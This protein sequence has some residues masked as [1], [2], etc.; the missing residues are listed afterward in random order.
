MSDDAVGN[1]ID[2]NKCYSW[3]LIKINF[4]GSSVSLL[5]VFRYFD[6]YVKYD[7]HII[8]DLTMYVVMSLDGGEAHSILLLYS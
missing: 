5:S 2:I 1:G 4:S 6:N 3:A 7:N 8:E